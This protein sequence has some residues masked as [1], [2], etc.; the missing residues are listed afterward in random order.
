MGQF[1]VGRGD[2]LKHL[3]GSEGDGIAADVRANCLAGA[4]GNADADAG[5]ALHSHLMALADQLLDGFWRGGCP[6]LADM[7]FERNTDVHLK[8]PMNI[9]K[10]NPPFGYANSIRRRVGL[11]AGGGKRRFAR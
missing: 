10:Q 9:F 11:V 7:G 1:G 3:I 8:P 2:H 4:V 5:T 6:R